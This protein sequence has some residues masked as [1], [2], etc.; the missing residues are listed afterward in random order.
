MQNPQLRLIFPPSSLLIFTPFLSLPSLIFSHLLANRPQIIAT[1]A[2]FSSGV[3]TNTAQPAKT[4]TPVTLAVTRSIA[5]RGRYGSRFESWW[6]H[7]YNLMVYVCEEAMFLSLTL[8]LSLSHS[9]P[10]SQQKAVCYSYL[11]RPAAGAN[12]QC[13][14]QAT[15]TDTHTVEYT[16]RG[17]CIYVCVCV[18]DCGNEQNNERGATVR[19]S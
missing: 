8:S 11:A 1:S 4:R 2:S 5:H 18:C 6:P 17:M 7:Y 3:H 9:P 16:Q 10:P 19:D 13:I 15:T 14:K 12:L